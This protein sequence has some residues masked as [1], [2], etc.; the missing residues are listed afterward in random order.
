MSSALRLCPSLSVGII[1]G[2]GVVT[3][4][5]HCLH[6]LIPWECTLLWLPV[7]IWPWQ[8]MVLL[9]PPRGRRGEVAAR[10]QLPQQR[11]GTLCDMFLSLVFSL[12]RCQ[13]PCLPVAHFQIQ[14]PIPR[15]VPSGQ[16]S[17]PMPSLSP[18]FR[19]H[20]LSHCLFCFSCPLPS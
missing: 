16:Q 18:V 10:S 13:K 2:K 11:K 6:Y 4:L 1:V 9:V 19:G 5:R 15:H 20:I 17:S 8:L 12:G 7:H 3:T 14:P